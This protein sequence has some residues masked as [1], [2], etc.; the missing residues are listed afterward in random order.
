MT[1][2]SQMPESK[3]IELAQQQLNWKFE[4]D[5]LR[6]RIVPVPDSEPRA[7][8]VEMEYGSNEM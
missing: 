7:Y 5:G 4:R 8:R 3:L 6:A 1:P 2:N